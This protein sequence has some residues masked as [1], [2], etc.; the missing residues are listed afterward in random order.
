[1]VYRLLER[2][3]EAP[4][5]VGLK[6][7]P[8][9]ILETIS[10]L[11]S[12]QALLYLLDKENT[13][14]NLMEG[15]GDGWKNTPRNYPA[16]RSLLGLCIKENK[17]LKVDSIGYDGSCLGIK[18][19]SL[20]GFES[21]LFVPLGSTRDE[22]TLSGVLCCKQGKK[23]ELTAFEHKIFD[24][25]CSYLSDTLWCLQSLDQYQKRVRELTLLYEISR[26]I[27][28]TTINLDKLLFIILTAVTA[29]DGL[30][31]NRAMLF[32]VNEKTRVLQG[33][34]GVG[35]DSAE[36]AGR[37][38]NETREK[39]LGLIDLISIEKEK[40]PPVFSKLDQTVKSIR[41]SLDEDSILT[42][43][44]KDM[45]PYNIVDTENLPYNCSKIFERLGCRTFASLP[46]I[47]SNRVVGVIVVDNYYNG[48][49]IVEDDIDILM[50][51]CRQAGLAVDNSL[52]YSKLKE[53]H[54]QLIDMQASLIH[55]E[56]MVALGEMAAALAHEIRNPLVAIG[57]F[58]KRLKK[59][60]KENLKET[61]L[62]RISNE[63]SRLEMILNDILT[64]SRKK[65]PNIKKIDI[66]S[67]IFD[68]LNILREEFKN[69]HIE[70]MSEV[71]PDLPLVL[72]DKNQL[73]Q[74]FINLFSNAQHAMEGG[75]VLKVR[76]KSV[77]ENDKIWVV[78]EIED[79]GGGIP[80]DIIGNVFNPFFTTKDQGTGL[81]LSIV[82]TIITKHKGA[83]G[84]NNIS[85]QGAIFTLT[86][87]GYREKRLDVSEVI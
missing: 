46:L 81:G 83:I 55:G 11:T 79:T 12:S 9:Y 28:L 71:E 47:A 43:T 66:T 40:N 20:I 69:S 59:E 4:S 53:S 22:K 31:F 33:M 39:N 82:H 44:V 57:G 42:H 18:D 56:K 50:A 13:V 63:V 87:P 49:P 24:R 78:T 48:R 84:V 68:C 7:R 26:A 72:A 17:P 14:L 23:K 58:A 35:P 8:A 75:G 74:V 25:L 5:D 29:G 32:L 52:L 15:A 45:R 16:D 34:L 67:V 6:E 77:D 61:Y 65:E 27:I 70:V 73:S 10:E 64:F 36:E 86:L 85:G 19:E 30:G 62:E 37:I 41:F 60:K 76:L 2:I 51:F 21:V 38:W 54:E 1:M 80:A 3:K